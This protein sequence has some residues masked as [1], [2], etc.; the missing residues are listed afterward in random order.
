MSIAVM[1]AAALGTAAS[2]YVFK[3]TKNE[4]ESKITE[5][6]GQLAALEE[7]YNTML[8]MRDQVPTFWK[9]DNGEEVYRDLVKTIDETYTQM[10]SVKSYMRTLRN[11]VSKLDSSN[12]VV[13]DTLDQLMDFLK[14]GI[15]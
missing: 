8:Q 9:D 15:G 12:E 5:L 10:E 1:G 3:Y 4:Y 13:R 2:A 11:V 7:H 6:E 14:T